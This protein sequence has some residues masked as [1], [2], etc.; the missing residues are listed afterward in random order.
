[1]SA[2]TVLPAPGRFSTTNCRPSA[3]LSFAESMRARVSGLPPGARPTRTR[4]GFCGQTDCASARP[5]QPAANI[6]NSSASRFMMYPP[7]GS[8]SGVHAQQI[9]DRFGRPATEAALGRDAEA[10]R[11][12]CCDRDTFA[13]ALDAID[14]VH[15]SK[16]QPGL[17][18]E[19]QFRKRFEIGVVRAIHG[20]RHVNVFDRPLELPGEPVVDFHHVGGA[21]RFLPVA[22]AVAAVAKVHAELHAARHAIAVSGEP[23]DHA[24][25]HIGEV[26]VTHA[27]PLA[28]LG[29]D[30]PLDRQIVVRDG[31]ENLAQLREEVPSVDRLDDRVVLVDDVRIQKSRGGRQRNLEAQ[32]L[33][34]DTVLA[35]A[36]KNAVGID[37]RLGIAERADADVLRTDT[38]LQAHA[39]RRWRA[40]RND[41]AALPGARAFGG[42]RDAAA[43]GELF[44]VVFKR[45]IPFEHEAQ[46]RNP[47]G[48]RPG[49]AV[50]NTGHAGA[51]Q[52]AD[53]AEDFLAVLQ[54]DAADEQDLAGGIPG[55]AWSRS[56]LAR[57][58][59]ADTKQHA[60]LSSNRPPA[61]EWAR[62]RF[63]LLRLRPHS[64]R[65]RA[66]GR[67]GPRAGA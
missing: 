41:R 45:G 48:A 17:V 6:A 4:T 46:A 53:R 47:G 15:Q 66:P 9:R 32:M 56:G 26:R 52:L 37:R 67:R 51:E 60:P 19:L 38:G 57:T 49:L 62:G 42:M 50:G 10:A 28:H 20:D 30:V 61:A 64:K 55:R 11:V 29:R 25:L 65:T 44:R 33:R 8:D 40:V 35:Q 21:L 59:G 43:S 27:F 5:C 23:L 18:S 54:A 14:V 39:R 63:S 12:F 16:K 7:Y 3:P 34:D 36:A 22:A 58:H 2:A 1:M 24:R 31:G 13:R